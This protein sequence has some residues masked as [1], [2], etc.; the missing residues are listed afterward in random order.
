M[1]IIRNIVCEIYRLFL[2]PFLR[3][4]KIKCVFLHPYSII[5]KTYEEKILLI[6]IGSPFARYS[7]SV[8]VM[9]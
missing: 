2:R 3:L 1:Q 5:Y 6:S 4:F 9:L 8:L 7:P